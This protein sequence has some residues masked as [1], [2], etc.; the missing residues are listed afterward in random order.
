MS[1]RRLVTLSCDLR[2]A[3]CCSGGLT[4]RRS[5]CERRAHSLDR[6]PRI[7]AARRLQQLVGA[8]QTGII[9]ASFQGRRSGLVRSTS[10]VPPVSRL[11]QS[12]RSAVDRRLLPPTPHEHHSD[13]QAVDEAA[14][15]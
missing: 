2:R 6:P 14:G 4:P 10:P 11:L 12:V 5:V 1:I 9:D 8:H 13:R 7:R 3:L 15:N